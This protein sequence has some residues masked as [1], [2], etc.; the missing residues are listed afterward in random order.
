MVAPC[1]LCGFDNQKIDK[2]GLK[3]RSLK[4]AWEIG[5]LFVQVHQSKAHANLQRR[6]KLLPTLREVVFYRHL[7][8]EKKN[9][10]HRH[11]F[12]NCAKVDK[13]V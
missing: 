5:F 12:F 10:H 11:Q 13:D 8:A 3:R 9:S 4:V 1:R 7:Q 2:R 6:K